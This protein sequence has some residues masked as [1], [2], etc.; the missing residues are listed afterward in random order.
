MTSAVYRQLF[1]V[2]VNLE[3]KQ[4]MTQLVSW[5]NYNLFSVVWCHASSI[6]PPSTSVC[7]EDICSEV[8][9]PVVVIVLSV[10]R[11]NSLNDVHTETPHSSR[12]VG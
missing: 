9:V 8:C 4:I 12:E 3:I 5:D 10:W 2:D 6:R 1:S 7:M 11:L